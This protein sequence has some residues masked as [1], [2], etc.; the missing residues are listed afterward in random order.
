MLSVYRAFAQHHPVSGVVLDGKTITLLS[1]VKI[2]DETDPGKVIITEKGKFEIE[3]SD[4]RPAKLKFQHEGYRTEVYEMLPGQ[5]FVTIFLH[6]VSDPIQTKDQLFG[7]EKPGIQPYG[8][9]TEPSSIKAYR[10]ET[11][12]QAPENNFEKSRENPF[13]A[14]MLN[15]N[16]ASFCNVR[17]FIQNEINVPPQ[18]VRIEELMNYYHYLNPAIPDSLSDQ[19]LRPFVNVT[20]CPW[21]KGHWLM[22]IAVQGAGRKTD[23]MPAVNLVL[24]V[25]VSGSMGKP[26]KL[27]LLKIAFKDLARQLRPGDTIAIVV[28]SGDVSVALPPTSGDQKTKILDVIN[29]LSAGGS[30]AGGAGIETAFRLAKEHFNA[31]GINRVI[32]ATDGDFNVGKS[33]DHDM[34]QLVSRYHGWGIFLT[35]MGVGTGNYKD[36]KLETLARWGQGNFTYLDDKV[37]AN[38]VFSSNYEALMFPVA[39]NARLKLIFD[40]NVV[41]EYRLIGYEKRLNRW[42]TDSVLKEPGG[43]IGEGQRI[44]ACYELIPSDAFSEE[45]RENKKAENRKEKYQLATLILQYKAVKENKDKLWIEKIPLQVSAFEQTAAQWQF[46][47]SVALFGLLLSHSDHCGTGDF[48]LVEKMARR[49]RKAVSKDAYKNYLKLVKKASQQPEAEG[50]RK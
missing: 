30:T 46:G 26:D 23:T 3:V 21:H 24:L 22:Q 11:Y 4:S 39:L 25:D 8:S 5:D 32:I 20:S 29:N 37:E 41:K 36:S 40:P 9:L 14:F 44:S 43:E 17:R 1:D 6:P 49:A 38:R 35:C 15:A 34:Q 45:S 18:A 33:S 19:P 47:A 28:Y 16:H 42:D 2:N 7:K 48:D 10:E 27:P 12:D 13:S 50:I 31:G